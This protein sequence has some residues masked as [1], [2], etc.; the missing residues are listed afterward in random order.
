MNVI[1]DAGPGSAT[2]IHSQIESLRPVDIA[3]S[4]LTALRQIHQLVSNFLGRGIKLSDVIVRNDQQ[5][6]ANVRIEIENYKVVSRAVENKLAFVVT[7]ISMKLA[8]NTR[9]IVGLFTST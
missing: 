8:K 5:M 7:V 4:C 1:C 2:K 9:R 6:S 3:Q